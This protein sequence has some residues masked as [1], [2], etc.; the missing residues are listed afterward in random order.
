LFL[1]NLKELSIQIS[2]SCKRHNRSPLEISLIGVSKTKPLDDVTKAYDAGLRQFGENFVEEFVEKESSF[3][4]D[5]LA[6]HF[7]GRLPRKKVRKVVGK[8]NLIHTVNS[9]EL[10]NKINLVAEEKN[11]IQAVLIQVNQGSESSKS[12]AHP[13]DVLSLAKEMRTLSSIQLLGLMSIPPFD[14][15]AKPYFTDL[16]NLRDEIFKTL[17]IPLPFLSMGMSADFDDAIS[18]GATHIRIG[19]A[20]FGKRN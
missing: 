19:T 12:G 20:I 1:K 13:D 5:D 6:Y 9:I 4:P 18:E 11:I 8:A 15:P 14:Q 17:D 2:D 7:I 10:A 3:H 16:R